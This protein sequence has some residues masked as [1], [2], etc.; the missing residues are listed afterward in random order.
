MVYPA[1]P[2]ASTLRGDQVPLGSSPE[3]SQKR[4]FGLAARKRRSLS[5]PLSFSSSSYF[6]PF[7]K[8]KS[9]TEEAPERA[10]RL[11]PIPIS[12][13]CL[14]VQNKNQTVAL[15]LSKS[16]D[17]AQPFSLH[18]GVE[19]V[20]VIFSNLRHTV[21]ERKTF[22]FDFGRR[23]RLSMYHA[24]RAWRRSSDLRERHQD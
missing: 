3:K 20:G 5:L 23:R 21:F 12:R 7:S 6:L 9:Q 17:N 15:M 16:A 14:I 2:F 11:S 13:L 4:L 18:T 24:C 10:K 1:N 19:C 22:E 8:Q